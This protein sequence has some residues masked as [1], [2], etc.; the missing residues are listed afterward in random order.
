MPVGRA[1]LAPASACFH[2]SRVKIWKLA[3]LKA[4]C[5]LNYAILSQHEYSH[6]MCTGPNDMQPILETARP[7]RDP[8]LEI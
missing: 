8:S 6:R 4:F 1:H 2:E 5:K 3:A 7:Y